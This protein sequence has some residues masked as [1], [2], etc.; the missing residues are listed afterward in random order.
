MKKIS[1]VGP[2]GSGKTT[3]LQEKYRQLAQGVS[4][5]K[6]LVLLASARDVSLWR[7][8][9]NLP[10]AG[11]LHIYTFFGWVQREVRRNWPRLAPLLGGEAFLE[12]SFLNVETAQYIMLKALLPF[13]AN[14]AELTSSPERLA[15]QLNS[16]LV[17]AALNG[18]EPGLAGQR[19]LMANSR[20][21]ICQS[22]Q[23]VMNRYNQG[24]LA[25]GTLDYAG[26]VESY[27]Q[28]LAA[29]EYRQELKC[30]DYILVDDVTELPP[31]AHDLVE[32]VQEDAKGVFL[33]FASD[34]GHGA[35]FGADPKAWLRLGGGDIRLVR[36]QG[37]NLAPGGVLYR[38]L[39][40]GG[41]G[42]TRGPRLRFVHQ[43]LR[44]NML[45]QAGE[46]V[47]SLPSR[48]YAPGEIAVIAPLVDKVMENVISRSL[49][50]AGFKLRTLAKNRRLIDEPYVRAL[51]TLALLGH[52]HWQVEWGLPDLA[53][54]LE[55]LLQLDPIRSWYLARNVQ[56]G[57]LLPLTL[58]QRERVGFRA[59]AGYDILR[60]WLDEYLAGDEQP[61]D[62]YLQRVFGELLSQ[63][64]PAQEDL[65]VCR[66]LI[67]SARKFLAAVQRL[68]HVTD[69]PGEAFMEMLTAGTVA[70]DSLVEAEDDP[71]AILLATPYAYL[72]THQYSRVQ[73]WL[74]VTGRRWFHRDARELLNPHVFSRNWPG[75]LAWSDDADLAVA[76]QNGARTVRALL[77]RCQEELWLASADVDSHGYDQDGEL[78]E[79]VI[80][81]L[82]GGKSGA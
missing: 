60:K 4:T 21:Q 67:A 50:R 28:L 76:R 72:S 45:E 15:I 30:F 8:N 62:L 24:L 65:V 26:A 39:E 6:I 75:D 7:D 44:T 48:G 3:I 1:Y 49:A 55:L 34:G 2:G 35:F 80:A 63:L 53:Q 64:P 12:P 61:L 71:Q 36:R 42:Q 54:S 66:Q 13:R 43:D 81:V 18:I 77:R 32:V 9:L 31:G 27:R 78:L 46:A 58:E 38:A 33:A 5:D 82:G 70:A 10:A 59:G 57:R 17:L 19:L 23:E 68:P 11:P 40:R 16:S 22:A 37:G 74:D 69:K 29:Q 41:Q 56:G 25:G 47:A 79:A 51:M 14:F 52:P 73:V 20:T